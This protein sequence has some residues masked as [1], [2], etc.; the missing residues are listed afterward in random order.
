MRRSRV[1]LALAGFLLLGACSSGPDEATGPGEATGAC[2]SSPGELPG[3]HTA[4]L[5]W[6]AEHDNLR[7]RLEKIGLAALKQEGKATDYHFNVTVTVN[8]STVVLP[9]NIGIAG[10]E[11][12]GGRMETG[13]VSAIHTHDESGLVHIHSPTVENFT[14]GQFFDV[15]GVSFTAERL[16]GFCAVDGKTVTVKAG[17]VDIKGD[18]RD[19][20]IDDGREIV[21][22]YG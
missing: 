7:A 8:G 2:A 21:V 13:F 1:A 19:V 12:S 22:A 17:G 10:V 11:V 5:P 20:L 16:G 18:P 6:P 15:W 4:G 9:S 3:M 14:L